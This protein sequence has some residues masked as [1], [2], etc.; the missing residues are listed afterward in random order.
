M[1]TLFYVAALSISAFAAPSFS[2]GN[3]V[4]VP[5]TDRTAPHVVA[6]PKG[7]R[8]AKTELRCVDAMQRSMNAR[9]SVGAKDTVLSLSS[10]LASEG[11]EAVRDSASSGGKQTLYVRSCFATTGI[12]LNPK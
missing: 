12:T 9:A 3:Q 1:K 8:A 4:C 11:V 7:Y 10:C 2:T 6:V 5:E